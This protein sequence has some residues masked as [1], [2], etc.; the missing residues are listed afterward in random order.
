MLDQLATYRR[1]VTLNDGLRVLIR[2]LTRADKEQLLKLFA[3]APPEDA[4]YFRSDASDP[5]IVASWCDGLDY[6]KVFPLV[7]LVN[8]QIIGDA[9]LHIGA[10]YNRHI[11]WV[12]LY[13]DREY[14]QRGVGGLM[15][16]G[17]IDIARKIGLQQLVAE[18]VMNQ[19]QAIKAFQNLGFKQE[20]AY[21]DFYMTPQGE[22]SDVALL[23]LRIVENPATF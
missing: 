5:A 4:D 3:A 12:R 13:L 16:S 21:R 7:A 19:V 22:T 2:P 20:F 11:G 1:L 9:T 8:D 6:A 18:V 23:I 10:N 17:L 15:L 14:R